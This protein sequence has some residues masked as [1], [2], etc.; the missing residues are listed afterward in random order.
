M[1]ILNI[2]FQN[3]NKI[4]AHIEIFDASSRKLWVLY[5]QTVN[6]N[7]KLEILDILTILN[8]MNHSFLN[9]GII[10]DDILSEFNNQRS[11]IEKYFSKDFLEKMINNIC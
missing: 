11:I 1:E 8:K 2:N 4:L 3:T 9:T 5:K 10:T 7:T 6:N